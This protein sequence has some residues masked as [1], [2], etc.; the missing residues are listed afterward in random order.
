MQRSYLVV[1]ITILAGLQLY[2]FTQSVGNNVKYGFC[3]HFIMQLCKNVT[4][5]L[6]ESEHNSKAFRK[7]YMFVS[8]LINKLK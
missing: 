6:M 1:N 3:E 4:T 2:F 5:E 7:L 8:Q